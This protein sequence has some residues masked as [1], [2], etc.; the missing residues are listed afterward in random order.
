MA[1][2][3]RRTI[4]REGENRRLGMG[5]PSVVP[6]GSC[7]PLWG[8]FVKRR[9]RADPDRRGPCAHEMASFQ[10]FPAGRRIPLV[11]A[12]AGVARSSDPQP[13]DTGKVRISPRAGAG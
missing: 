11:R 3:S 13:E 10:V 7:T 6:E 12:I 8:T 2:T 5:L 4:Q 9:S 1:A